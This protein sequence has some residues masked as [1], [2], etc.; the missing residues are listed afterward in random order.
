MLPPGHSAGAVS[1]SQ[2]EEL[3]LE[4][5]RNHGDL[6]RYRHALDELRRVLS[7]LECDLGHS[8]QAADL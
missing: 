8:D 1:K 2:A 4:V 6:A 3:L 7:V 5:E